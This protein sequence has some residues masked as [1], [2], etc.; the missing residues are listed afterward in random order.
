MASDTGLLGVS[1]VNDA[2]QL[3]P[4]S[5]IIGKTDV[6]T[7]ITVELSDFVTGISDVDRGASVGGIAIST[8]SGDGVWAYSSDGVTFSDFPETL[9]MTSALLLHRNVEVRY[10]PAGGDK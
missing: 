2:P 6:V 5:P 1:D 10:T 9:G 7:V 3:N 8:A 4:T